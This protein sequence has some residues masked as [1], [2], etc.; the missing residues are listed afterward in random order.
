M[1]LARIIIKYALYASSIAV[2]NPEISR[3]TPRSVI[4]NWNGDVLIMSSPPK[5]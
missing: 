2:I 3:V 1:F 5:S 4:V